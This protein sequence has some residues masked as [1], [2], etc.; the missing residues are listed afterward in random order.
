MAAHNNQNPASLFSQKKVERN[1]TA[2]WV[3]QEKTSV[4]LY[5]KRKRSSVNIETGVKSEAMIHPSVRGWKNHNS[6]ATYAFDVERRRVVGFFFFFN[7]E[8]ES[9]SNIFS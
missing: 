6:S 5:F 7:S 9:F 3:S 1:S 2:L 4:S 8:G